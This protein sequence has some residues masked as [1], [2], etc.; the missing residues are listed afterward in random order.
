MGYG[1]VKFANKEVAEIAAST[2]NGY[3]MGE[4]KLVCHLLPADQPDP[5][6]YKYG[7]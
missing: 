2:M 5:F 4:K 6:K 1:F 3:W 7:S